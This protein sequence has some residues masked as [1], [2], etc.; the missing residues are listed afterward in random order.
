MKSYF[1]TS[2]FLKKTHTVCTRSTFKS[3]ILA[4][5][6]FSEYRLSTIILE[7]LSRFWN[8]F[9][10]PYNVFGNYFSTLGRLRR[11]SGI[12]E[13]FV[14]ENHE[15]INVIN[16]RKKSSSFSQARVFL[17]P[18]VCGLLTFLKF[19]FLKSY[20][21]HGEWRKKARE[22][23]GFWNEGSKSFSK[24]ILRFWNTLPSLLKLISVAI[25]LSFQNP[26][27]FENIVAWVF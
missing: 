14:A 24:H 8:H 18:D 17:I 12:R 6:V 3:Y 7:N 10:P 1:S 21:S 22:E 27:H 13:N 11:E 9:F 4:V 16:E 26:R 19:I 5:T 15:L 23:V 2:T 25:S 20:R